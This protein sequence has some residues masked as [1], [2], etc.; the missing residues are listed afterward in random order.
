MLAMKALQ[1]LAVVLTALAL[2]P[3][4]AHLLAMPNKLSLD[5]TAYFAVQG[6]YRGWALLGIVLVVAI[7]ADTALAIGVRRQPVPFR[8]A[9]A[10]GLCLAATLAVFFLWTY[11]ANQATANW[12]A[13]P[14]DW[15]ALRRQWEYSHAANAILTFVALCLV[16]LSVLRWR[17]G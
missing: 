9:L 11:P 6:T 4:G 14:D 12:T 7:A 15:A 2:V 13:V 3:G 10:G 17:P 16:T 8:L 5:E 1:F